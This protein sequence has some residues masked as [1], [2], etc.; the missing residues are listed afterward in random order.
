M[1]VLI[2]GST[3]FIGH[4]LGAELIN[5]GH[6]VAILTRNKARARTQLSFP[7][8]IYE[9]NVEAGEVEAGAFEQVDAVINLAGHSVADGRWTKKTKE[10]ILRSRVDATKLL[11]KNVLGARVIVN[12]SAIGI[13]G[14]RRDE[15][16]TEDSP[17]GEGFL[18]DVC[19]QWEGA[20]FG[21]A[22]SGR[23]VAVRIGLVLGPD[24]GAL[25]RIIPMSRSGIAGK[26]GSGRQWMSW[27]HVQD[28]ASLFVYLIE[29]DFVAGVVN[30]VAPVPVTNDE[31][32][33]SLAKLLKTSLIL[34]VPAPLIK[35]LL[36]ESS[37]LLLA[38]QRVTSCAGA[39][40]FKFKFETLSKA[41]EDVI[42]LKSKQ[43]L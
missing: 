22:Y 4:H 11:T 10:K 39:K 42:R 21:G 34:S 23:K 35:V 9:W 40:L 28:L 16:L 41:L 43:K 32:T 13:Y 7:C 14:D 19:A 20:L 26:L 36:G 8:E 1:K 29:N 33:H 25:S 24:G 17:R 27:I 18:A 31:F 15:I 5:R 38:S 37:Q 6:Q 3:G 30:G 12:A 2:S